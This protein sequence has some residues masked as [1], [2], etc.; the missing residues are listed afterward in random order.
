MTHIAGIDTTLEKARLSRL[1]KKI[2]Q[3]LYDLSLNSF[4]RMSNGLMFRFNYEGISEDA[5][6]ENKEVTLKLTIKGIPDIHLE[7]DID[8]N[9]KDFEFWT[10]S[11]DQ[12]VANRIIETLK[13]LINSKKY[14]DDALR[15]PNRHINVEILK[16]VNKAIGY[17]EG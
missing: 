13:N 14:C 9:L 5:L 16:L 4:S 1:Q 10:N 3:A 8:I 12:T 11:V 6:T 7:E 15:H 17:V 2:T